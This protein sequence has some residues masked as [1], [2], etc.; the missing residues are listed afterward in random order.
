M[1][2]STTQAFTICGTGSW[3]G[4]RLIHMRLDGITA[5][6]QRYPSIEVVLDVHRDG[7]A[8]RDASCDRGEREA[9]GPDHVFQR[10]VPDA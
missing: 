9:D 1:R 6:L 10:H 2:S 5:I 3:I 8:E 4:A 7:V